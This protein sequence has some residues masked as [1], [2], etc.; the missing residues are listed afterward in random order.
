MYERQGLC[1]FPRHGL[2]PS[3]VPASGRLPSERPSLSSSVPSWDPVQADT[4]RRR[5]SPHV[6]LSRK[7]QQKARPAERS[8]SAGRVLGSVILRRFPRKYR[9]GHQS[10][11]SGNKSRRRQTKACRRSEPAQNPKGRL[12]ATHEVRRSSRPL[13]ALSG[14]ALPYQEVKC[15]ILH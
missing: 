14:F 7:V 4:C 6:S 9:N 8:R 2:A 15:V 12:M 11:Q 3:G 5:L 1:L 10:Y 13:T